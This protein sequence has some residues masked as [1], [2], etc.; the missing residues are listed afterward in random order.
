MQVL[1]AVVCECCFCVK[2]SKKVRERERDRVMNIAQGPLFPLLNLLKHI[3]QY[4]CYF[5]LKAIQMA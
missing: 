1:Y 4:G 5:Y 3:Y 2:V